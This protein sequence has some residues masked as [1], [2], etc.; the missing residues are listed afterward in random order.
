VVF[1]ALKKGSA[2]VANA[3]NENSQDKA[4]S[5]FRPPAAYAEDGTVTLL[6]TLPDLYKVF[7]R[8]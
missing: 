7:E 2:A 6:T 8:C 3:A 4:V 1:P 5:T